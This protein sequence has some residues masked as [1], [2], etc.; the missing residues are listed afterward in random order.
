[1]SEVSKPAN[2]I[3]EISNKFFDRFANVLNYSNLTTYAFEKKI[4]VSNATVSKILK[5][6]NLPSYDIIAK[7]LINYPEIDGNWL[8]TGSGEMLKKNHENQN[9]TVANID[10]LESGN[11]YLLDLRAAAGFGRLLVQPQESWQLPRFSLPTLP[12]HKTYYCLQVQGESMEPT[13]WANDFVVCHRLDNPA[14]LNSGYIHVIVMNDNDVLIKRVVSWRSEPEHYILRSDNIS[15][16]ESRI[17]RRDVFQLF[18]VDQKISNNLPDN[19]ERIQ[20]HID[21]IQMQVQTLMEAVKPKK[22][23]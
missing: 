1:M 20:E 6:A 12:R 23:S 17:L 5:K 9:F 3:S 7:I 21:I 4:G 16:R 2:S 14:D 13:I 10:P 19:K 8:I 22:K 18:R 11:I 15:F